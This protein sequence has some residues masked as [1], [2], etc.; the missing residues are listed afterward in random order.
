MSIIDETRQLEELMEAQAQLKHYAAII[1]RVVNKCHG[2]A[3][4]FSRLESERLRQQT[5]ANAE[6]IRAC[7]LDDALKIAQQSADHANSSRHE[8]LERIDD[9]ERVAQIAQGILMHGDLQWHTPLADRIT[10]ESELRDALSRLPNAKDDR[11][12]ASPAPC[13]SPLLGGSV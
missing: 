6:A 1:D 7:E 13:Q 4:A 8:L 9:L 12:G 10:R 5:R 2:S 11:A 3:A